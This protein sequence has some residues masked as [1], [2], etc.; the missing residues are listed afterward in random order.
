MHTTTLAT[1]LAAASIAMAQRPA[2]TSVCDYY[3]TALLKQ[4]TASNQMTL[5]T[6]LVNTAVIGNY[7]KPNVGISVPGIL[8]QGQSL[9]GTPVDLLPYFNGG[10][11]SSNR[12]GVAGVAVNFL[13]D[14]DAAP[15][16][17]NKPANT[18]SSQHKLL[19][20]LYQYFGVLLGCTHIDA[21]AYPAYAGD[22]SMYQVH[23][24]MD[25]DAM[26]IGW[27][28]SQ[29]GL[30][31]KSF[32]VADADVEYVGTALQTLFGHKCS[33]KLDVVPGA[34]AELQAICIADECPLAANNT[35]SA[36]AAAA[37][38]KQVTSSATASDTATGTGATASSTS[39]NGA[40]LTS[41]MCGTLLVV[42]ALASVGLL[43][44]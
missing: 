33:A 11:A 3:T 7:T 9:N 15:L 5:V 38:P 23:K 34:D 1:L 19:T 29:V 36:Y 24:F 42:L 28:I 4:N 39:R 16:L 31:A 32:G 2:N 14:G 25:L 44:M 13:D 10:L 35:C 37:K 20:H 21:P 43:I 17:M 22:T 27:F 30:S 8:A 41:K 18:T 12:G 6:L 40:E 26:E